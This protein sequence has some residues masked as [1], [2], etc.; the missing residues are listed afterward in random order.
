[1]HDLALEGCP[2]SHS[3]HEWVNTQAVQR[4]AVRAILIRNVPHLEILSLK[5]ARRSRWAFNLVR[6]NFAPSTLCDRLLC[7]QPCAIQLLD[8]DSLCS[9]YGK[10]PAKPAQESFV[11][12]QRLRCGLPGR[13]LTW[14]EVNPC[15]E[16]SGWGRTNGGEAKSDWLSRF[17]EFST[18]SRIPGFARPR[19]NRR[20]S[21]PGL[22]P[23][24]AIFCKR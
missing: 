5:M 11:L 20:G 23:I 18:G 9:T 1:M 19:E 2:V 7:D 12:N 3:Y 10:F 21:L 6:S 15:G 22:I 13:C 17:P 4:K 16:F 24:P 8:T 14:L